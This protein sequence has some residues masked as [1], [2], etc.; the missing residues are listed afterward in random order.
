MPTPWSIEEAEK[1]YRIRE[2]GNNF[3]RIN[4]KG[5]VEVVPHKMGTAIDLKELADD[6]QTKQ[7]L[8]LP[9]LIRF[10]DILESQIERLDSC[11][12]KACSDFGYRGKYFGVYPIKVNQQRQVI[13]EMVRFGKNY[14]FGLE[15]GSKPELHAVLA[16]MEN[17]AALIVCNGYKDDAFIRMALMGQKLDRKIIIVVE[18]L[19]ELDTIIRISK[20][21]KIRPQIGLRIKLITAGSGRWESSGGEFSKFGLSASEMVVAIET[22]K[23]EGVLECVELLHV[24]LGSQITNIRQIKQGM[25]EVSRYYGELFKSGCNIQ[26][27]DVG[28]G[29]GVDYDGSRS[30]NQAS[31]NYSA[32][33][34]ANDI[35]YSLLEI[36]EREKLPHPNIVSESGRALTAHHSIMLFDVLETSSLPTWD[37]TIEITEKDEPFTRFLF[38]ILQRIKGTSPILEDWHDALELRDQAVDKFRLGLASLESRAKAER[39]FWSIARQV[40][41]TFRNTN[42]SPDEI[43]TLK[44]RLAEKYFCN[45]S[46]FQSIPDSWAIDQIFPIMPIHRLN[47]FPDREAT[48]QDITCDSDGKVD[49]FMGET[50]AI[51]L[52]AVHPDQQYVLGIFLVG[53]YQE[54]LGDLH[55]LFGDTNTVHVA[56]DGK[57]GWRYEQVIRGENVSDV[58]E[59]VQFDSNELVARMEKL[60]KTSKDKGCISTKEGKAL[61]ALYRDGLQGYTYLIRNH[62]LPTLEDPTPE[63]V[64]APVIEKVL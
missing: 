26:Y 53:A 39:L 15:A 63:P 11:F 14:N 52:H 23:R 58:L 6:V 1:L 37:I 45:F 12:R 62:G 48:L 42:S 30:T 18:K 3:F 8:G 24:H 44:E 57:G 36:C 4:A 32:Q 34:Y 38:E 17:P 54:I 50:N 7:N 61:L 33:E 51:P 41:Q 13:E 56:L 2:W 49:Q 5:H 16:M 46:I 47:E 31:I 40:Y 21:L 28:G 25:K 20:E 43:S 60:I 19:N 59:Y 64:A 29:L 55:N 9:V 27:V 35:V 22:A 10:S